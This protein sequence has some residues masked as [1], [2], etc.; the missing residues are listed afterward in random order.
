MLKKGALT[1][2]VI[3][4]LKKIDDSIVQGGKPS[5]K[6]IAEIA[7]GIVVKNKLN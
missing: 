2:D 6:T 7:D 1:D 5:A 4:A 3:V